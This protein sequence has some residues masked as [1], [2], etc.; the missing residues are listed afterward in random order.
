M[1]QLPSHVLVYCQLHSISRGPAIPPFYHRRKISKND[2]QFQHIEWRMR[3][4][5]PISA[6]QGQLAGY[7]MYLYSRSRSRHHRHRPAVTFDM[8][9]YALPLSELIRV[10]WKHKRAAHVESSFDT[11]DTAE[12]QISEKGEEYSLEMLRRIEEQN[13]A[14]RRYKEQSYRF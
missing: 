4:L 1:Y 10:I 11:A 14:L 13:K 3:D 6:S 9:E 12:P 8:A 2:R 7:L 5:R